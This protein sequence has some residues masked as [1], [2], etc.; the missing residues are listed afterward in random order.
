[1]VVL[2][3]YVELSFKSFFTEICNIIPAVKLNIIPNIKSF[4]IL[5]KNRYV[6]IA[7]NGSDKALMNV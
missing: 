4:I 2:L 3:L 7:P 1:M 6:I 5:D